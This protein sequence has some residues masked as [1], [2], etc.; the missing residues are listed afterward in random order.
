MRRTIISTICLAVA[1]LLAASCHKIEENIPLE[2]DPGKTVIT[3]IADQ[4]GSE[5][6][7]E[8]AYRYDALWQ[9]GDKIHVKQGTTTDT[10]ALTGGEGTT[11]GTFEGTKSITGEIEAFYPIS[12]GQ[13]MTWPAKQTNN[14][15]VPM[16]AHQSITG[17]EG[18]TVNFSS[19]GAVLQIV[20]NSTVENVTL[21]SIE[22]KDGVKDMS[23][24]FSVDENGRAV[25]S[26]NTGSGVTLDL[27]AG[28]ALGK[29]ANFFYLSIPAG[30]YNDLTI[31]FNTTD[32]R[33]CTMHSTT[34]PEVKHNTVCRLTLTGTAFEKNPV[35]PGV[36]TVDENGTKVR[37]AQG[38]LFWDGDSFEFEDNQ[39]DYPSAWDAS[40][41]GHFY[42]S[43]NASVATAESFSD[44]GALDGDVLFTNATEP[45]AKTDFT[46]GGIS[47]KFRTLSMLEW[48]YILE[49][50]NSRSKTASVCGINGKVI[51]PDDFSGTLAG[52]YDSDQW[53]TA[54]SQGVVFLP[55]AGSRFDAGIEDTTTN[56]YYWSSAPWARYNAQ[57]AL[58]ECQYSF[59]NFM[60]TS[61]SWACAIR[62][63]E[64][65]SYVNRISL[66]KTE[67]TLLAHQS[68][69]LT[70]AV[71]PV[72]AP[73]KTVVWSSSNTDVATVSEE[74]LV[75]A[76]YAGKTTIT[77]TSS[78]GGKT[79]SCIVTV[80]P[81]TP[82]VFTVDENGTKVRFSQGNLF[83]DGDS[84]EF[85]DNQYDY[86]S[87]WDASH[88]GHFYWSRNA[89]VATAESFSDSGALD[90]DVLFTNA[91]EPG[92]KADF[93]VGGI[94][95]KFRTL[96]MLEWK[97]ILENKNSRS[98]T[99][100]VCGINGKVIAPDD[101]SGTLAGSYDS[102]QWRTA[103][104][105]GV[106][107]LPAA[108]SRFDARI[109]DTTTNG[110]YWS[111]APWARSNAQMALYECQ[112][113]FINFMDTS[114]S[115]ACAIRLVED[116]TE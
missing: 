75:S 41:V 85:E 42:W 93:T 116:V 76:V 60:D 8:M 43:R 29:G 77:A 7:V 4:I 79:A 13:T 1:F 21:Q 64:D 11:K 23:G 20:F 106:V 114:R 95:G 110:Y 32:K 88:V 67:L 107:F 70:V 105:Q 50:K 81:V 89:S 84:F 31:S 35:L 9:T 26:T 18:E 101:F 72:Y 103:E 48:K 19:L 99:T 59:I 104:S 100:S 40:H 45:G 39:Y 68:A 15:A 47:G 69:Q 82:G 28:K 6:K 86:P 94:S 30:K 78:D 56:G 34:M 2:K 63:V 55:A 57:M 73:D 91:T 10:F 14:M 102:D 96:S 12:V 87:A 36:F 61:R 53:R 38:N 111:S 80:N 58:F 37:F 49:G 115:W 74:G 98:K 112:Y 113:S 83:W 22:L 5:T 108:G 27:G 52:S 46:V 109:E 17:E 54:E 97:Y 71:S 16:Y 33:V 90:G 65:V 24:A 92:A 3:A 51:A 25:I 62:L 66:D 44:S